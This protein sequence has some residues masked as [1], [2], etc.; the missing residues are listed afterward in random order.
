MEFRLVPFGKGRMVQFVYV[1][2][3]DKS[4]YEKVVPQDGAPTAD[5]LLKGRREMVISNHDLGDRIFIRG[6]NVVRI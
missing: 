2:V 5:D 1:K 6:V 4:Y 3:V